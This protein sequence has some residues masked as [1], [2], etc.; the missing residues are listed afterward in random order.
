MIPRE[1]REYFLKMVGRQKNNIALT[2]MD[3]T[4]IHVQFLFSILV[5]K[6]SEKVIRKCLAILFL[7][8]LN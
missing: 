5:N 6:I 4:T 7:L 3:D 2:I 1:L 8:L